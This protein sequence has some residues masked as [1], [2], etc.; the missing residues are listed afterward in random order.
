MK[1]ITVAMVGAGWAGT[2][3]ARAYNRVY[4]CTPVLKTV[5]ALDDG[6]DAFA[7]QYGFASHTGS[8]EAVLKDPEIDVV[9]II[10]PPY[11]HKDMILAALRAGK[12]VICEKPVTGYFGLPED[13][14]P[15]GRVSQE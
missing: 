15:V 6:M 10:T 5:C 13:E 3:H 1:R 14:K 2:M 12:H 4:G 9:D 11:L 7:K 8:F